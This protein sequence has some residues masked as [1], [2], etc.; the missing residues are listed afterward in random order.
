MLN[1]GKKTV[2]GLCLS[3]SLSSIAI[4][5]QNKTYVVV[6]G[7]KI[8]SSDIAVALRDP[9]VQFDK[10]QPAQQKQILNNIVEQTLLAQNAFRSD[11]VKTKEYKNELQ[12][13]KQNLAYQLWMRDISKTIDVSDKELRSFYEQNKNKFIKPIEL[14]ASHILVATKEEAKKII[15]QL[16]KAK[17]T[18][19]LFT[20]LA[21]ERSTGP[22]GANGGEL[23]WFTQDK[24]VP[25]FS[26]AAAKLNVG[27]FTKEPV[28]TQYGF[29]I[30]Y[31]DDKKESSTIPFEKIKGK[32]KQQLLQEKFIQKIMKIANN[33]KS[34]AKIEYK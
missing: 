34:N 31:L 28:Q 9:R 21:K 15:E 20:K 30:I 19:A 10:L 14:K 8:T 27:E 25:Q 23:G 5:Q 29:H 1:I 7:Q 13:L 24:M 18:K 4:A 12:K 17:D 32:L 26:Q 11:I 6:N 3:L 2:L 16:S 33:L 22:S